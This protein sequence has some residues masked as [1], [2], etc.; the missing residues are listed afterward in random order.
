MSPVD[1][2]FRGQ[3]LKIRTKKKVICYLV[4]DLPENHGHTHISP[5]VTGSSSRLAEHCSRFMNEVASNVNGSLANRVTDDF[6]LCSTSYFQE[7]Q[8][9]QD[10][11]K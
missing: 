6:F 9:Y 10:G 8:T 5:S 7:I 3:L 4:H 2:I 1:T 11:S